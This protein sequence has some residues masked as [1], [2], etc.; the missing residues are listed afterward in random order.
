M[1]A[2]VQYGVCT[3]R[4]RGRQH[5]AP[6]Q[7]RKPAASKSAV[8]CRHAGPSCPGWSAE[9]LRRQA[10][11]CAHRRVRWPWSSRRWCGDHASSGPAGSRNGGRP[12][13]LAHAHASSTA[14]K[15]L[16]Y[17]TAAAICRLAQP[18]S[19]SRINSTTTALQHQQQRLQPHM[20][21]LALPDQHPTAPSSTTTENATK[22]S[23]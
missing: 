3:G 8:P 22:H 20:A 12:A 7:A 16:R 23:R 9:P 19:H 21:R 17:A 13:S 1:S 11:L 18:A 14:A 2:A 10:H 5:A 6:C 15:A 4:G